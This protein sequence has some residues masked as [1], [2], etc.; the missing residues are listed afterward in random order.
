MKS[1]DWANVFDAETFEGKVGFCVGTGRCGTTFFARLSSRE[2]GVAASHERQRLGATFH[3]FCK[4]HG[5]AVDPEGFLSAKEDEIRRDLATDRFSLECNALLSHSLEELF[6]RFQARFLL[7][8]RE[9]AS[10]VA[11]FAVRGWFE[12]TPV[13]G[14]AS[15]PPSYRDGE[16][17]RHFL[18]RNIPNGAEFDRW[19]ELTQIGRLA[20][21]WQAR[22]LAILDQFRRLPMSHCRV[23]RLEDFDY[24]SYRDVATFLGWQPQVGAATFDE[25]ARAR[26]NAG[27]NLP[28]VMS[29]WNSVEVAE[30]EAE[31]GRL[32]ST[33][34]YAYH[35][36]V[37]AEQSGPVAIKPLAS[38]SGVLQEL[39][40]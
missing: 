21:F 8:I 22:N 10:T 11:S 24:P 38:L 18:G 37:L 1:D 33:L 16:E 4:W 3:M 36:N 27:P 31:V 19:R 13:R 32:A 14:N 15:L 40:G 7:L 30:F 26:L 35:G 5:I 29:D 39:F 23:Q 9:P 12:N 34:G 6:Q 28:R 25:L 20:W 2:P 17:A